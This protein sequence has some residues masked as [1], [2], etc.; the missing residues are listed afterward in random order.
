MYQTILAG[1]AS[2]SRLNDVNS[3]PGPE[4]GRRGIPVLTPTYQSTPTCSRVNHLSST[5]S[6]TIGVRLPYQCTSTRVLDKSR[7]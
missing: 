2:P 7:E 1:P 3:S 5:S 4:P 6:H